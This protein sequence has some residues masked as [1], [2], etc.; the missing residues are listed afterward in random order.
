KPPTSSSSFSK[1]IPRRLMSKIKKARVGIKLDMTAM[2][3]V[4]FLLLI[5]YMSTTQFK[6]PET[7]QV[8]LPESHADLKVPDTNVLMVYV[9]K[10]GEVYISPGPGQTDQVAVSELGAQVK[11]YRSMNPSFRIALKGDKEAPYGVIEDAMAQLQ[12]VN[13]NRFNLVTDLAPTRVEH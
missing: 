6:P 5:F 12:E 9:T 11:K 13:A 7:V 1:R 3:D 4:A 8:K 2:V 10:A